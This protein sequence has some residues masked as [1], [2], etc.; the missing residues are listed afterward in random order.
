MQEI[1]NTC[2]IINFMSNKIIMFNSV[3]CRHK[4]R[5]QAELCAVKNCLGTEERNNISEICDNV[6][7]DNT[8][9]LN[10]DERAIQDVKMHE[11]LYTMGLDINL[12]NENVKETL[13]TEELMEILESESEEE[14]IL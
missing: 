11:T 9:E 6:E 14:Q 7:T 2:R 10:K 8:I 5:M 4:L 13:R 1:V 12:E 3:N